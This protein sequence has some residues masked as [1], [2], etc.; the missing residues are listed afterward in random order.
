[1]W[2]PQDFN[3]RRYSL[4]SFT[5]SLHISFWDQ[6]FHHHQA[7]F[8]SAGHCNCPLPL[9]SAARCCPTLST[10]QLQVWTV[11]S[12]IRSCGC[13]CPLGQNPLL[14]SE[15]NTARKSIGADCLHLCLSLPPGSEGFQLPCRF[16]Y[17]VITADHLNLK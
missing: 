17:T 7:K 15:Q 5:S 14:M 1:M 4:Y 13:C 16:M 11:G 9:L 10:P 6:N 8:P 2:I 3:M 12:L